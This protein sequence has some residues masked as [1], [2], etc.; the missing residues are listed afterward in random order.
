MTVQMTQLELRGKDAGAGF[1][2]TDW[3]MAGEAFTI[4]RAQRFGPLLWAMYSP[5]LARLHVQG[6]A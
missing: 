1:R 3:K 5:M 4:N 6:L 2:F